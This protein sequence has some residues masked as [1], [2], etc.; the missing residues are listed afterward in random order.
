[1]THLQWNCRVSTRERKTFWSSNSE[2][3]ISTSQAPTAPKDKRLTVISRSQHTWQQQCSERPL[4]VFHWEPKAKAPIGW[5][6]QSWHNQESYA[7]CNQAHFTASHSWEDNDN[8]TN[9]T[10]L[11]IQSF[12]SIIFLNNMSGYFNI[13]NLFPLCQ[14][15]IFTATTPV[16]SVTRSF[17]NYYNMLIWCSRTI[18][19]YFQCWKRSYL[20]TMNC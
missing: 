8:D 19:D 1:M 5:V 20:K 14:S 15:W 13:C 10:E 7:P 17:R 4:N 6:I 16:F 3:Y 9:I 2:G 12:W 11:T 18:F